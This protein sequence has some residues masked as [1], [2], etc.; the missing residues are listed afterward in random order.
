MGKFL[1]RWFPYIDYLKIAR[2]GDAEEL[3][4]NESHLTPDKLNELDTKDNSPLHYAARY[5]Y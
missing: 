2:D 5:S 3:A 1:K 4:L